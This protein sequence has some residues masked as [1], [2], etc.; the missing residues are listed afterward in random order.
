LRRCFLDEAADVRQAGVGSARAARLDRRRVR[1][2]AN[3]AHA[4]VRLSA[5]GGHLGRKGSEQNGD[6]ESTDGSGSSPGAECG[7]GGPSPGVEV[8]AASSIL[9]QMRCDLYKKTGRETLR[10]PL[11]V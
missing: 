1:V 9:V 5:G 8:A 7:R 10:A 4:L 6:T 3:D 11:S 2:Q